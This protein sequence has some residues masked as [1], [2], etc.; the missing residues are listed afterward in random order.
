MVCLYGKYIFKGS[1]R[2]WH[3]HKIEFLG[4][5]IGSED[6]FFKTYHLKYPN[7]K[8]QIYKHKY[9]P[10]SRELRLRIED[11]MKNDLYFI[12]INRNEKLDDLLT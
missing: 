2:M 6:D 3:N 9:K 11:Y 4:E 8:L 1:S 7:E 10:L 5:W 12:R